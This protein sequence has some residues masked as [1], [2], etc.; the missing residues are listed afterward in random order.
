MDVIENRMK[1]AA[2]EAV[3][4]EKY[5]YLVLNDQLDVCVEEVHQL[6][7]REHHRMELNQDIVTKITDELLAIQSTKNIL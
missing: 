7:Q 5:D 4:M 2:D 3:F 1:R 6:I